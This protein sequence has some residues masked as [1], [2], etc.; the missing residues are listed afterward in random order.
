MISSFLSKR[1]R[2][3]SLTRW[4]TLLFKQLDILP[5]T[6]AINFTVT[7]SRAS[8]SCDGYRLAVTREQGIS[9][10]PMWQSPLKDPFPHCSKIY[11]KWYFDTNISP[12]VYIVQ[13]HLQ[14]LS[15]QYEYDFQNCQ[16][17][18]QKNI[19]LTSSVAPVRST[20]GRLENSMLKNILSLKVMTQAPCFSLRWQYRYIQP[21]IW[22][23]IAQ[24]PPN[25]V[26]LEPFLKED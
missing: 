24:S 18:P 13:D 4:W 3:V 5:L 21:N 26:W 15:T 25:G 11:W 16:L 20:M 9:E 6:D 7:F 12:N 23:V 10:S 14:I 2:L 1:E 22:K 8:V 17:C 19:C